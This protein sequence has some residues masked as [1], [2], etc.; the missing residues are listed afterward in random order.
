MVVAGAEDVESS[1]VVSLE[2]CDNSWDPKR[3]SAWRVVMVEGQ[4]HMDECPP[5]TGSSEL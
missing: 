1:E 2:E 3:G 4:L 5:G